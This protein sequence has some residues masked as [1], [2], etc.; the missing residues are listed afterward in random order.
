MALIYRVPIVEQ[1]RLIRP[2]RTPGDLCGDL[3]VHNQQL[4]GLPPVIEHAMK[5]G[6]PLAGQND[7]VLWV[8]ANIGD[9]LDRRQVVELYNPI[10]ADDFQL[11]NEWQ[12]QSYS[13]KGPTT[14]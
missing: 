4:I 6:H 10:R 11:I 14:G 3:A 5:S 12:E 7:V 2:R 9:S 8:A 1:H 13:D